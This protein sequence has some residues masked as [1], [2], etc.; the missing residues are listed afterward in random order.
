MRLH[1]TQENQQILKMLDLRKKILVRDIVS[2]GD[3]QIALSQFSRCG[4]KSCYE[5][6]MLADFYENGDKALPVVK[7]FAAKDHGY[8]PT[9]FSPEDTQ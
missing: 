7:V 5:K 3:E 2:F 6:H 8:P 1:F 9:R 4:F